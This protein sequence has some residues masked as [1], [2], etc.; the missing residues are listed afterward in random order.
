MAYN[1]LQ[2]AEEYVQ[3]GLTLNPFQILQSVAVFLQQHRENARIIGVLEK[4]HE[5]KKSKRGLA[6]AEIKEIRQARER[7]EEQINAGFEKGLTAKE[8]KEELVKD[9]RGYFIAMGMMLDAAAKS[10]QLSSEEPYS[11]FCR[12]ISMLLSLMGLAEE[13]MGLSKNC[14]LE[15]EEFFKKQEALEEEKRQERL[16]DIQRNLRENMKETGKRG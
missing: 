2:R 9:L 5:S 3:E 13:D 15:W 10:G 8:M 1:G 14:F 12:Q 7:I 11:V 16:K 4:L 6:C